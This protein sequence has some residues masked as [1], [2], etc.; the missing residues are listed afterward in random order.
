MLASLRNEID[1]AIDGAYE[2]FDGV[3][4]CHALEAVA[5]QYRDVL[6]EDEYN[7][8]MESA[9]YHVYKETGFPSWAAHC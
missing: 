5:R 8:L 6:P 3:D 9:L 1:R 4:L 7:T 2:R